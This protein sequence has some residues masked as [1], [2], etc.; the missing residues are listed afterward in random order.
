MCSISVFHR[1]PQGRGQFADA[2]S[3]PHVLA[4]IKAY[5]LSVMA[6]RP[7]IWNHFLDGNNGD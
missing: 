6:D 7:L 3:I 1:V 4:H 2:G 5:F